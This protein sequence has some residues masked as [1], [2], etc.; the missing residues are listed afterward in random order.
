MIGKGLFELQV[1]GKTVGFKFGVYS[2]GISE[3]VS[4]L[5]IGNIF[6]NIKKEEGAMLAILHYFYGGA[7]VYAQN[8]KAKEP[9]LDE[10]SDL[11]ELIGLDE[12]LR[13]F[14]E[15]LAVPKNSEAPEAMTGL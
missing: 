14:K 10:V 15:S 11:I 12:C 6:D 1:D 3:K 7:V 8:N 4:G 2:A 5:S 9:T 13:I